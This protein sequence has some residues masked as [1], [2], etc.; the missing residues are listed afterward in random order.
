MLPL[1]R[2]AVHSE[3]V[4]QSVWKLGSTLPSSAQLFWERD[5]D[6]KVVVAWGNDT[7]RRGGKG[8]QHSSR[9]LLVA[10]AQIP[11][12]SLLVARL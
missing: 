9:R 2:P 1:I 7:V 6:T 4:L 5:C 3:H 12:C 8:L 10:T 11:A